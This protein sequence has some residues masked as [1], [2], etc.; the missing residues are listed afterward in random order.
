MISNQSLTDVFKVSLHLNCNSTE[1][2]GCSRCCPT[3]PA[4]CC[5]LHNPDDF[6]HMQSVPFDKPISQPQRSCFRTTWEM[7]G[8]DDAFLLSL[9]AWCCE[10]TEKKY[11]R[12]H[13]RDIGPS[14][15][16]SASIRDRIVECTHHG[17]IKT[18]ADVERETKW[19]GVKEF[20]KDVIMLIKEHHPTDLTFVFEYGEGVS[21]QPLQNTGNTESNQPTLNTENGRASQ[22]TLSAANYQATPSAQLVL[23]ILSDGGVA[24]R[25]RAPSKCSICSV[26]GHTSRWIIAF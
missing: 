23:A 5:D 18:L 14:L 3:R 26:V 13:L 24:P 11:G 25:K 4:I 2:D 9:E 21:S 16:M 22:S 12:A 15:V 1:P 10:Q 8:K 6:A 7:N 20:G 17:T 19:H